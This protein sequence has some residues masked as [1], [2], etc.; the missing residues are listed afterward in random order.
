MKIKW[1]VDIN[2][3]LKNDVHKRQKIVD[4]EVLRYMDPYIPYDTG[5]LAKSAVQGTVIGSGRIVQSTPYA[6]Y[7]YYGEVYGPNIPI[8]QNGEVI[9]FFSPRGQAKIPTGR[10]LSYDTTKH[11]LAGKLWFER[12]KTDHIQDI[13][14]AAGIKK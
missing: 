1:H 9:G 10:D 13:K 8:T 11:P 5:V 7:L 12:M 2:K 6:R 4:S 3:K 14:K